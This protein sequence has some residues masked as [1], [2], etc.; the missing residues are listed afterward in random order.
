MK[1]IIFLGASFQ[2]LSPIEYANSKGYITVT[3]DNRPMNPGHKI[4]NKSYNIST[5]DKEGILNV[6]RKEHI[7]GI[8]CYASDISAPTAAY[9]AE[10]MGLPGNPYDSVY[11]L[12]NKHLFRTFQKEN[13]FFYPKSINVDIT[14]EIDH[15]SLITRLN[16]FDSK[17]IIKPVD[18]NACKGISIINERDGLIQAIRNAADYSISNQVIIEEYIDRKAYQICGEGFIQSGKICFYSFANEH[19]TESSIVP[20]GESFPTVFND[21]LVGKAVSE[22][23]RLFS[24]LNMSTGPFNVDLFI[25]NE[26]DV[27]IVEIGPRNG[28]NRMPDAIKYAYGVDTIGATVESAIGNPVSLVKSCNHY[29]ST[30]SIHTNRVG[31]LSRIIYSDEIKE[32]IV[33]ELMFYSNGDHVEKFNIGSNMVGNLILE[34]D[35][36]LEMI[37]KMENMDKLIKVKVV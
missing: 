18:A 25:T 20:V 27:F 31:K 33:N 22:L 13:G 9:V 12:T 1:R 4:A 26:N 23:Q 32:N 30:Y 24:L 37:N 7:D 10:S 35:T 2:Q 36:Y 3:C 5:I 14:N 17:L 34:F 15:K 8:V 11:M 19:F 16:N 21:Q 28:G 29:V 6:A